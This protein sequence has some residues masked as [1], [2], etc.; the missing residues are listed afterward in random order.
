MAH[1]CVILLSG[2]EWIRESDY[3]INNKNYLTTKTKMMKQH[4]ATRGAKV[5]ALVMLVMMVIPHNV[6]AQ[7]YKF[8]RGFYDCGIAVAPIWQEYEV[9][10]HG[11]TVATNDH[12]RHSFGYFSTTQGFYV[13][14]RTFVGVGA[15]VTFDEEMLTLPLFAAVKYNW[16][17]TKVLTPT[18]EL[19]AGTYLDLYQGD[20]MALY[21]DAAVGLRLAIGRRVA[22]NMLVTLTYHQGFSQFAMVYPPHGGDWVGVTERMPL[23]I[24]TRL[25][26]EF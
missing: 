10:D 8:Y 22:V 18:F 15:A 26:V 12:R 6:E 25:G 23:A 5:A 1:L 16:S 19:R 2:S 9:Y 11:A 4:V 21:G 20:R 7:I 24:G 13:G 3:F 17:F 14:D